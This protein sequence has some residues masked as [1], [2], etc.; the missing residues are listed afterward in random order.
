MKEFKRLTV[1]DK[2]H[3]LTLAVYRATAA[4]PGEELGYVSP[5]MHDALA[6][7]AHEIQRMLAWLLRTVDSSRRVG[8]YG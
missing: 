3:S 7:D 2:A 6:R 5:G 8:A 4:F 1:W